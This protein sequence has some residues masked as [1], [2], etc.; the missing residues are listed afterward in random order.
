[1]DWRNLAE[2]A[3]HTW[4]EAFSAV[5]GVTWAASG[6][7]MDKVTDWSSAQHFAIGAV[8]AVGA[9]ALSAAKTTV[10]E[11]FGGTA[12]AKVSYLKHDPLS[13]STGLPGGFTAVEMNTAVAQLAQTGPHGDTEDHGAGAASVE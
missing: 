11:L 8:A 10:K 5:V 7:G 4:W 12:S 3:A 13:K 2:R 9:A 6:V 1:M